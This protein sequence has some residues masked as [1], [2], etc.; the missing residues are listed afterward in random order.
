MARTATAREE[1]QYPGGFLYMTYEKMTDMFPKAK[2]IET[3]FR[4]MRMVSIVSILGSLCFGVFIVIKAN[5]MVLKSE[6]KVYILSAGKAF[7]AFASDRASNIP[8]E[9]RAHVTS[10]MQDFF[11]LDPD[12][13]MIYENIKKAMYLADGSVKRIYDNL[14]ESGYYS[15][16]VSANI[17]QRVSIDSISLNLTNYPFYFRCY[18]TETITRATSTVTRDLVTEGWLRDVNRSDNDPHGFLIERWS[19]LEN[20]DVK[21]ESRQ[22]Q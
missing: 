22:G 6:A 20:K 3:S 7:E 8:V 9:A 16:V 11:T 17:S 10:F 1:G 21:V 15:G 13:K 2:N 5:D 18:A 12:E 19:I 14:K 4:Q